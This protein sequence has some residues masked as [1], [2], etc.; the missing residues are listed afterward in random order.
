MRESKGEGAPFGSFDYILKPGHVNQ[1]KIYS[2]VF[3]I[4]FRFLFVFVSLF[5]M[6]SAS[7]AVDCWKIKDALDLNEMCLLGSALVIK[8]KKNESVL[9]VQQAELVGLSYRYTP[10]SEPLGNQ[11]S[12]VVSNCSSSKPCV[13][14]IFRGWTKDIGLLENSKEFNDRIFTKRLK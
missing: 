3:S 4:R 6:S 7:I 10:V 12:V 14:L 2:K 1:M 5:S 8:N 9:L 13:T 11:K